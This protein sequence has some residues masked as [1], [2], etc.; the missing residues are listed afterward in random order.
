[1]HTQKNKPGNEVGEVAKGIIEKRHQQCCHPT[2][3]SVTLES[4]IVFDAQ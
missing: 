4:S 1:M 2:G 3:H